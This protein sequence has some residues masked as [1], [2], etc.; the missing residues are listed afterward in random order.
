MDALAAQL[1]SDRKALE[2]QRRQYED[3]RSQLD[4]QLGALERAR[5]TWETQ[6]GE[7]RAERSQLDAL[8]REFDERRGQW[9]AARREQE[10][11]L[12]RRREDVNAGEMQ[13]AGDRQT[14]DEQRR[15]HDDERSQLDGQRDALEQD[16]QAWEA[17]SREIQAERSQLDTLRREFDERRGQWD[18]AR[19]QQ[20]QELAQRRDDLDARQ[21][22]WDLRQQDGEDRGSSREAER[23]EPET[24][25]SGRLSE[26]APVDASEILGRLGVAAL[27][28]DE[29]SAAPSPE[30]RSVAEPLDKPGPVK[31]EDDE[32]IHDY[33]ARLM[34]RVRSVA[35]EPV[36]PGPRRDSRQPAASE[37]EALPRQEG[38][39][40]LSPRRSAPEN[41]ER[42][43]AMREVA[44]A[45]AHSAIDLHARTKHRESVREKLLFTMTALICGV[46]LI[47]AW[48]KFGASN[49]SYYV[50]LIS[51]LASV[52]WAVRY[53]VLSGRMM[54]NPSGR[55]KWQSANRSDDGHDDEPTETG[56]GTAAAKT[57]A[58]ID[59]DGR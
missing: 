50:G 34:Q 10:Q 3:Q 52:V 35:Q 40:D 4:D 7:F 16:R 28:P 59:A 23:Q 24:A 31:E 39:A 41:A 42:L 48:A 20:E 17:Q 55:L 12:V 29:E 32:S 22:E 11:E 36:A 9:D 1:E 2:E 47:G 54:V 56:D 53:A 45:S 58:A 19:R 6:S 43:S 33:M 18:A 51:L 30:V 46:S 38:P 13:L 15:Q 57:P 14:L 27:V 49:V 26:S 44:S 21:R 8:R 5:Q 25:E 37:P